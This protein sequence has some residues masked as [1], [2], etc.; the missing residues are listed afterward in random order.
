MHR[1]G[2]DIFGEVVVAMTGGFGTDTTPALL[3]EVGQRCTLDVTH[4]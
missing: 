3:V 1:G 2:I 4:V